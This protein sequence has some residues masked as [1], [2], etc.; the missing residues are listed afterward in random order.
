M[1]GIIDLSPHLVAIEYA[2]RPARRRRPRRGVFARLA[3]RRQ[4]AVP[5]PEPRHLTARPGAVSPVTPAS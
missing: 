5:S 1:R 4:A 3:A 2:E